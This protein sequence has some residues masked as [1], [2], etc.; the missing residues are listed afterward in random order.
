MLRMDDNDLT[1]LRNDM[2]QGLPA[3]E[4]LHLFDNKISYIEPGAFR[5]LSHLE[6]L[7]LDEN[8]LTDITSGMWEGLDELEFL[9]VGENHVTSLS[10][11][12]FKTLKNLKLLHL[13]RNGL[14]EIHGATWQGLDSLEELELGFNHIEIIHQFGFSNLPNLK[15][16]SLEYNRLTTITKNVFRPEDFPLGHPD[17][18]KLW[19]SQNPLEC[20]SRMCWMKDEWITWHNGHTPM[21][22][23]HPDL[24]WNKISLDCSVTQNNI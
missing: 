2:F 9:L 10:P 23:N 21:C 8:E 6:Y 4:K 14:T 15:K 12:V 20:D 3:L 7:D 11:G 1:E 5:S 17:H 24:P 22:Q 18:L 19:I 13:K 16:L